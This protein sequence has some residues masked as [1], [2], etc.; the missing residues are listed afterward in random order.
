MFSRWIGTSAFWVSRFKRLQ[1]YDRIKKRVGKF[2]IS[3]IIGKFGIFG[4]KK[5]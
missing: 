3:G 1:I 5:A 2:G 4:I